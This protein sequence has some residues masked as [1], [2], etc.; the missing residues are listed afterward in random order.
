MYVGDIMLK[1]RKDVLIKSFDHQGRGIGRIDEKVIFIPNTIPGEV[2]DVN[3]VLEKKN[4]SIGDLIKINKI[5]DKR[6]KPICPHFFE[7]GGCDLMHIDYNEE[8]EYKTNK[9]KEVLKKFA[10]VDPSVVEEITANKK[11]NNYRN[12]VSF[13]VDGD[14]GFYARN[15]ND[16]TKIDYC[17]IIDDKINEI[18]KFLNANISMDGIKEIV[19]KKTKNNDD[20]MLVFDISKPIDEVKLKKMLG[21]ATSIYI[22]ENDSFHLI[23]GKRHITEEMGDLDF[24]ISADSFFQVNTEQAINLYNKI[25]ELA[26][27]KKKD[28][29]LEL[30]SGTG[31]I[32]TFIAKHAKKV[33]SVEINK[34]AVKDA[35]EN[36]KINNVD[37]IEF[38]K[39]DAL[40]YVQNFN[41]KIDLLVVDPPRSGMDKTVVEKILEIEPDK[42]I[43]VSCDPITLARDIKIL[44]EKYSVEKVA[45]FDMFPNTYHVE[46]V[47]LLQR[48]NQ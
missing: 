39:D 7:C 27:P 34:F 9:I 45:P 30:Y 2:V 26:N 17:Y 11:R 18:L 19:V 15:T 31:T 22:R 32:S 42:M 25:I 44:S 16:I 38:I 33:Y 40:K 35:I 14:I 29:V 8:L 6:I 24:L 21:Y 28:I 48:K 46:N 41:E 43:Y 47:V 4:Y 5:S 1:E 10:D 12:K 13:K 23:H 36:A 20:L 3:V 37:N